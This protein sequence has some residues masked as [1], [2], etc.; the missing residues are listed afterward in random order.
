MTSYGRKKILFTVVPGHFPSLQNFDLVG[1]HSMTHFNNFWM[2]KKIA[3]IVENECKEL[4]K[5]QGYIALDQVAQSPCQPGLQH[6]QGRHPHLDLSAC[7]L[8]SFHC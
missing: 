2:S 3:H 7:R 5:W 1:Q 4:L 8:L 6:F